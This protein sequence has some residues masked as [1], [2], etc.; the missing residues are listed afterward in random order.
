MTQSLETSEFNHVLRLV[1]DVSSV[2]AGNLKFFILFKERL[3]QCQPTKTC[4]VLFGIDKY[5]KVRE[6]LKRS[7][8]MFGGF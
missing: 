4:F 1:S 3:L 6:E 8:L 5:K 2:R 7:P